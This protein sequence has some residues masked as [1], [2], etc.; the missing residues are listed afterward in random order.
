MAPLAISTIRCCV[1]F[2]RLL[3][4]QHAPRIVRLFLDILQSLLE[5]PAEE[6]DRRVGCM[7]SASLADQAPAAGY[8]RPVLVRVRS[9][10]L[11]RAS[12]GGS[13]R[14][15]QGSDSGVLVQQ[16]RAGCGRAWS[17]WRGRLPPAQRHGA[18]PIAPRR[19]DERRCSRSG[20]CVPCRRHRRRAAFLGRA[21]HTGGRPRARAA[22]FWLA[23]ASHHSLEELGV[24]A[25]SHRRGHIGPCGEP[26]SGN[27]AGPARHR[28]ELLLTVV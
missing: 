20:C 24:F 9:V 18:I 22:E 21:C 1:L 3:V 28:A 4:K 12:G 17:W 25:G 7:G 10:A 16:M 13:E 19:T 26:R 8:Q 2:V 6:R 5:V 27:T 11:A 14:A 23:A 15:S